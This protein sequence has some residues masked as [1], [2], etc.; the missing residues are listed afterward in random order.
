VWDATY[1]DIQN[2][3]FAN[4]GCI[5]THLLLSP[6]QMRRCYTGRESPPGRQT[7]VVRR[8]AQ[9]DMTRSQLLRALTAA[10][11]PRRRPPVM[12]RW[13]SLGAW[14]GIVCNHCCCCCVCGAAGDSKTPS[15][16]RR[17]VSSMRALASVSVV[18]FCSLDAEL[19]RRITVTNRR[20]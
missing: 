16:R 10:T 8:P 7:R 6:S 18:V 5:K 14:L 2:I 9:T 11:A 12:R 13:C 1:T 4:K 20:S 15:V 19:F 3:L 17:L